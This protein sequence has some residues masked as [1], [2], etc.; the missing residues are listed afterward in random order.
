MKTVIHINRH[1]ID[2]NRKTGSREPVITC[3]NY[4]GNNY[5]D[6]VIIKDKRGKE[7]ARIVYT[8]DKPLSCGASVYIETKADL[9]I[10]NNK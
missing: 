1:K 5:G 6:T 2:K 3:K 8:P 10:L 4:K 9:E 7:V